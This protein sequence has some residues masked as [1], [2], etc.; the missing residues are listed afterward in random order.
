MFAAHIGA[1]SQGLE[2]AVL[3][4]SRIPVEWDTSVP[5]NP[6]YLSFYICNETL[7]FC[8]VQ[9]KFVVARCPSPPPLPLFAVGGTRQLH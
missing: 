2:H 5:Q 9:P 4:S 7:Q 1:I 3:I 8:N 6:I